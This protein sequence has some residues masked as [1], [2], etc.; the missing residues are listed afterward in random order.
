MRIKYYER[1]NKKLNLY[2][3][4]NP[5]IRRKIKMTDEKPMKKVEA[6]IF[7]FENEGDKINGILVSRE[8]SSNYNNMVYKIKTEENVFTVFGTVVLDDQL[9]TIKDN[10]L[11]EIVFDGLKEN[12]KKGQ[13]SIKLFS[14]YYAE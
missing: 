12:P 7:K 6:K 9:S 10:T 5:C 11:I 1:G 14:V 8:K 13:N 2:G 4:I 3:I